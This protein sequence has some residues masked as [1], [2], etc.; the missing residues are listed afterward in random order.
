[1]STLKEIVIISGKGGTG[2]T[3]ITA[4]L[5]SLADNC[6][7]ADCDVDAADMHLLTSPRIEQTHDFIGGKEARIRPDACTGC[8]L[9]KKL[10]R[11]DAVRPDGRGKYEV[12][13]LAC[14]GCN[15]CVHFCPAKAIDLV[16]TVNGRWFVSHTR[17]G[18]MVH[19]ELGAAQENSGKLVTLIRR[20]ARAIA[21]ERH[22][23][24]LLV[25]G[26]PGI[27]CPVIASI[28]AADLALIV[29][30][31]TPSGL[32]DFLR[33]V[34]LTRHFGLAAAVCINKADINP[35]MAETI[36]AAA[37]E[38]DLPVLAH[39]PYDSI[40]TRAQV[41]AKIVLELPDNPVA[42]AIRVLWNQLSERL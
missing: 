36:E 11:F 28:T 40:V 17:L 23:R 42:D 12:D 21:R 8:G 9:C 19:A 39:I 34:E 14:E 16:E 37:R 29:T 1:M 41:Q 35:R 22:R 31:P 24:W 27:G 10:C 25:D 7:L 5:A 3:S 20:Q 38:K 2:K 30:E 26:S 32:H 13:S 33:M 18:P 4:A 6:V 15:V